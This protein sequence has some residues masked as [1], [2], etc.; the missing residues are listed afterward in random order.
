MC[1]DCKC[2][3]SVQRTIIVDGPEHCPFLD[4][5]SFLCSISHGEAWCDW[6]NCPLKDDQVLVR[7]SGKAR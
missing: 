5:D 6:M 7:I 3:Q 4:R 1:K 2:K